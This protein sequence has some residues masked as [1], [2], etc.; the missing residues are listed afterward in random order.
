MLCGW[1][2]ERDDLKGDTQTA[3]VSS[4]QGMAVP[5]SKARMQIAKW[6][7]A[8]GNK[9]ISGIFMSPLT[10]GSFTSCTPNANSSRLFAVCHLVFISSSHKLFFMPSS[11]PMFLL[12]FA[13]LWKMFLATLVWSTPITCPINSNVLS[14]ISA[15]KSMFL[16]DF[17]SS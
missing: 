14:L 1:S 8:Q 13:S 2:E 11:P 10:L 7:S 16:Y 6:D 12:Y 17:L 5:H 15:I 3:S 4:D 9:H